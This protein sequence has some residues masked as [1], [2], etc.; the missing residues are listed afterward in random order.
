MLHKVICN[1]L[2]LSGGLFIKFYIISRNTFKKLTQ[3]KN[4]DILYNKQCTIKI[5]TRIAQ[6]NQ[7]W[8]RSYVLNLFIALSKI[9]VYLLSNVIR[10]ENLSHSQASQ[11]S[12]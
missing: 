7:C 11:N 8:I 12:C 4:T 10:Q 5:V 9:L 3:Y 6:H 2:E 1:P